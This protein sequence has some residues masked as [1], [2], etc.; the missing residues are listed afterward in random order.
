MDQR[1]TSRDALIVVDAQNDF[2]P[3]GQLP[4]PDGDRIIPVV[5]RWIEIARRDHAT[6]VATR[7]WH[8]P[9]HCSFKDQGGDWPEHC[10]QETQGAELHDDIAL[11]ESAIIQSKGDSVEFDQYSGFDRTT[12]GDTLRELGVERLWIVGLAQDVCVKDTAIDAAKQGF[13]THVLLPG[14]RAV[15]VNEGDGDRAI[16]AMREAGAAI[17]EDA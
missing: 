4:V 16:E 6:V 15:N 14:T 3:G 13:D 5:N 9:N 8:P 7:D 11:P 12:L 10:V 2:F 17:E 1:L